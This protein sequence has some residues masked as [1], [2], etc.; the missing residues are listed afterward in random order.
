MNCKDFR[1]LADSYLSDEL[2]VETNHQ[3]FKHLEHCADCRA[4]MA[5]RREVRETLRISMKNAPEFQMNSAFAARLSANLREEAAKSSSWFN[6]K[7]FAPVFAT[8]LIVVTLGFAFIYQRDQG[9]IVMS[10]LIDK[11]LQNYLV[12]MSH[13][14]IG[15]HQYCALNKIKTWEANAG[16][17]TAEQA[18]FVKTLQNE[19]TEVLEAHDCIFE[20]KV[21][22]HYILRREGR[23]ISVSKIASEY[24][25]SANSKLSNSIICE[26]GDGLQ[27][28]SF[29]SDGSLVFV[30]SDLGETENLTMARTL[31]DSLKL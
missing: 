11:T 30:I 16:K 8:L 25:P 26:R 12:E 24:A 2:A 21:F 7:I 19:K 3:V 1:E 5:A 9:G 29:Q 27:V 28:A 15:D 23:I 4:E 31:S 6:W 13:K 10:D 20:G 17:V 18:S 22:T 14:A